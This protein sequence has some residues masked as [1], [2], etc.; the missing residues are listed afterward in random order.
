MQA[1]GE[2]ARSRSPRSDG[3]RR[4]V[5]R[6]QLVGSW[7][8]AS[9]RIEPWAGRVSV[10][11]IEVS[12]GEQADAAVVA[13]RPRRRSPRRSID[14]G[15]DDV[16]P[17]TAARGSAEAAAER[18]DD[19]GDDRGRREHRERDHARLRRAAALKCVDEDRGPRRPLREAEASRA[20]PRRDGS[21]GCAGGSELLHSRSS[22]P[23]RRSSH[24]RPPPQP[25][26]LVRRVDR[27]TA[28]AP[29]RPAEDGPR[30]PRDMRVG[31]HR[32]R[33]R[34]LGAGRRRPSPARGGPRPTSPAGPATPSA[35][36]GTAPRCR[37]SR[38]ARS[39]RRRPQRDQRPADCGTARSGRAA[40]YTV[41]SGIWAK[42]PPFAIDRP[43]RRDVRLRR[44]PRRAR[45]GSSPP[46]GG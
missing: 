1:G 25:A 6:G 22:R 5:R 31:E 39:A 16:R 20:R 34:T 44:R 14:D 32:A 13:R 4:D 24:V 37:P 29:R 27:S 42:T 36:R 26:R 43:R 2:R 15:L 21:L 7:S 33:A 19:R 30:A 35:C 41:P 9:G 23:P 46:T 10:T 12:V 3:A 17:A 28:G 38:T 8:R 11:D 45:P 18:R 40:R